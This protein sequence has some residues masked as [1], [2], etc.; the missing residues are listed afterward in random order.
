MTSYA[1]MPIA[2]RTPTTP[3]PGSGLCWWLNFDGVWPNV[4]ARRVRRG[5]S[6]AASPARSTEP[7]SV[8]VR[9]GRALG[10]EDR[11]WRDA[12]DQVF[13]PAV[14]I[15]T[16]PPPYPQSPVIRDVSFAPEATIVRKAIDSDNWPITWGDDDAQY[17]S[18]GDGKGF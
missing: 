16:Q 12:V 11:F 4:P 7:R 15:A 14:E 2:K 9:N 1:G 13:D 5:R 18:Y 8:V 17:T 10:P 6:R 3:N